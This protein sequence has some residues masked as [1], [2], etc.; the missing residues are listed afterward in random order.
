MLIFGLDNNKGI[1]VSSIHQFKV[2]SIEGEELDFAKFSG[3]KIIVVNVASECGYTSQYQQ[4]QELQEEFKD[5]LVIVG[6]PSNDFGNQEPG[7]NSEILTFCTTVYNV[8][9][10]MGSK[11]SIKGSNKH[12]LYHWLTSKEQNGVLDSEVQWNFNKY[13][14]NENGQLIRHLPSA[15]SPLDEQILDWLHK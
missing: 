9:F 11:I 2:E 3:K 14:L 5:K 1:I 8:R 12:P 4:L 6:F 10:P 15:V 13:L 7:S